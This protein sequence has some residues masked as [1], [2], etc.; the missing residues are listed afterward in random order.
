VSVANT[1]ENNHPRRLWQRRRKWISAGPPENWVAGVAHREHLITFALCFKCGKY[2]AAWRYTV[3]N[4]GVIV[5]QCRKYKVLIH[6]IFHFGPRH[7]VEIGVSISNIWMIV[8]FCHKFMHRRNLV[9]KKR[10]L[11]G[12]SI[13]FRGQQLC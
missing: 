12:W 6:V 7:M 1:S 9:D 4:M 2:D 5:A 13:Y 3:D 10:I 8:E 11:R